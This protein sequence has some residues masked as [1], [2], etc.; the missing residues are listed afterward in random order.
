MSDLA[1]P[2][3]IEGMGPQEIVVYANEWYASQAFRRERDAGVDDAPGGTKSAKE[4]KASAP[5]G[6]FGQLRAA[7][8]CDDG[9]EDEQTFV[10]A[11]RRRRKE[12]PTPGKVAARLLLARAFDAAPD[13]GHEIGS[14]TPIVIVEIADQEVMT[15]IEHQWMRLPALEHR[16]FMDLNRFSDDS[17]R[18][19]QDAV[20][21]IVTERPKDLDKMNRRAF[22]AIQFALPVI[23]FCQQVQGFV[24]QALI[25]GATHRLTVP[26]LDDATIRRVISVVTGRR[27]DQ[28][29]DA[30]VAGKIGI[31]DLLLGVRFDRTPRQCLDELF[32]LVMAKKLKRGSRDLTLDEMHGAD[33]AVA[34]ARDLVK[35]IAAWKR[36][37]GTWD[38]T[39]DKGVIFEG[40]PGTGKT[41]MA[42]LIC[43]AAGLNLI[44]ASYAQ[45]QG[46]GDGHLGNLLKSMA[47]TFSDAR[48]QRP[49]M[50]LLDEV[51]SFPDRNKIRHAL[52]DYVTSFVN[53]LLAECDGL[54][55][56]SDGILLCG[57]TN[58]ASRCDPAL[59]RSGRMNRI[60]R[61]G[62][63]RPEELVKMFRV[64]LRG[65]LDG[66]DIDELGFLGLGSSGA[67]VE[68]I[69]KDARRVARHADRPLTLADLRR[70]ITIEEDRSEEQLHRSAI[71]EAG[72]I[73]VDVL[74]FGPED[75]H[76]N[77]AR[78]HGR[79]G[80]VQR[81][82]NIRLAGTYDDHHRR[83]QVILA[84]RTAEG[85]V[86]HSPSMGAGSVAGSDLAQATALAAAMAGSFGLAGPHP[87]VFVGEFDDAETLLGH[88]HVLVSVA[89][90]LKRAEAACL[91]LLRTHRVAVEAVAA[92]LLRD[93]RTDG[94]AVAEAIGRCSRPTLPDAE[95]AVATNAEHRP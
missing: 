39:V 21:L 9:A 5:S 64:R 78:M 10:P 92:V 8:I 1:A 46:S 24:P 57:T 6:G 55:A 71:H 56:S 30:S 79:G 94:H 40:P 52:A 77:L 86:L 69:V 72:H 15:R 37:E 4:G 61:I 85:L 41:T 35:D 60:I 28:S 50:V 17:R 65:D 42:K 84:G 83:L 43:E 75:V 31:R 18:D 70:A 68:R 33:A 76:A 25:D 22:A 47:K 82:G 11:V 16:T 87:L 90:E 48:Q 36:G 12:P 74:H 14:G 13:L 66:V 91:T 34:Y 58:D 7:T 49:A 2:P 67:D 93:R 3:D 19:D 38:D 20:R 62:L 53:A 63:P 81:T 80:S 26:L 88:R 23:V 27:C 73:V 59:L 54:A 95:P 51:D 89:E 32:R 29:P 45:W 44:V